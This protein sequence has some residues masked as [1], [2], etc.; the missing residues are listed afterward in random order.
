MQTF[1]VYLNAIFLLRAVMS[2]EHSH[3]CRWKPCGS[4]GWCQPTGAYSYVCHCTG[5][6]TYVQRWVF[7]RERMIHLL[8][9]VSEIKL[10]LPKSKP[11]ITCASKL[12]ANYDAV[13]DK[14]DKTTHQHVY[15]KIKC[16]IPKIK[17]I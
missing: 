1:Y 2:A 4:N 12:S 17:I 15:K 11:L 14:E 9:N 3:P 7:L 13:Q 10:S 5:G 16:S 6:Y 8:K